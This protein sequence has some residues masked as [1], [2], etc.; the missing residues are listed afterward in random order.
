[1]L[2]SYIFSPRTSIYSRKAAVDSTFICPLYRG[3]VSVVYRVF[4]VVALYTFTAFFQ[5]YFYLISTYLTIYIVDLYLYQWPPI[6]YCRQQYSTSIAL[7]LHLVLQQLLYFLFSLYYLQVQGFLAYILR[8]ITPLGGPYSLYTILIYFSIYSFSTRCPYTIAALYIA[9]VSIQMSSSSTAAS[10]SITAHSILLQ[11]PIILYRHQFYSFSSGARELFA[12]SLLFSPRP[13]IQAPYSIIS[14]TTAIYSSRIR[15]NKGPQV[16]AAIYNTA[17][18]A[19]APLVVAFIIY[20]FQFSLVST[21]TPRTLRVA[22]SFTLQPQIL[23]INTKLLFTL[24][25]LIK[26]ISQYLSSANLALCCFAY[27]IYLLYAQFSLV[28]FSAAVF[29]YI[30]R[31]ILSINPRATISQLLLNISS[32]L[33]IKNRNRIS[34]RGNPYRIPIGIS[35]I[36]LLQPLNTILVLRPIRKDQVNL[37]IQSSRPFFLRIYRSLLY[38][39]Q[40][41]APLISRL[42]IDTIQPRLGLLYCLDTRGNQGDS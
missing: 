24:L 31:F 23:T 26:Q 33:D 15:L 27:I 21:Q 22:F 3:R 9:V 5:Y 4:Y 32:S 6:L 37:I 36:L 12:I 29:P 14:L 30:I 18:N 39:I 13:Q 28:Q 40:L 16:K 10:R 42:S 8:R 20:L 25:F 41:K 2:T 34:N 38:N 7:G 17:V 19:A 11:A 1:M 35:I